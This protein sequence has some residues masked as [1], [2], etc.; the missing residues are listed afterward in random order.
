MN[1]S[2]RFSLVVSL[3]GTLAVISACNLPDA[4][5][6]GKKDSTP[7]E[8]GGDATIAI[9][10]E[11]YATLTAGDMDGA[12]ALMANDVRWVYYGGK[13][14]IPFT[15]VYSGH[16]GVMQFF[17]DYDAVA[18][19]LGMELDRFYASGDTVFVIGVENSKVK[20]TGETYA[21]PWV[22]VIKIVEGKIVNYEEYIDSAVVAAAFE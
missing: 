14:K 1:F 13:G 3:V 11:M 5:D 10:R 2:M 6:I 12:L 17:A 7:D 8:D 20:A 16:E 15:G 22:H 18:E 9:A 21:A 19:P 4:S